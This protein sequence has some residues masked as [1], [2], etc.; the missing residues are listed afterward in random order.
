MAPPQ[1]QWYGEQDVE[2]S[3]GGDRS[4]IMLWTLVATLEGIGRADHLLRTLV[5][6]GLLLSMAPLEGIV[7][8]SLALDACS[9]RLDLSII[10]IDRWIDRVLVGSKDYTHRSKESNYDLCRIMSY[11]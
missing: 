9:G 6:D 4:L 3:A 5:F 7:R 10:L 11:S 1:K 2:G 8:R